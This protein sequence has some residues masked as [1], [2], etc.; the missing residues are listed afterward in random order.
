LPITWAEDVQMA[1]ARPFWTST[2]QD[3]SNGIK[4]TSG[5]GVLPSVVE[6]SSCGS[7]G[8]LQVPTF[9]N[10]SLIFTLSPKWDCDI[11]ERQWSWIFVQEGHLWGLCRWCSSLYSPIWGWLK[12]PYTFCWEMIINPF[13]YMC[14]NFL[15]WIGFMWFLE[16]KC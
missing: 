9:R 5:Q 16:N 14:I 8:G 12:R 15:F 2:L 1:H 4:N 11:D 6:L 3:L 7:R 10:V 13:P